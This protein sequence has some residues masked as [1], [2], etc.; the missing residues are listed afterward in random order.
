VECE[1]CKEIK[2]TKKELGAD[3]KKIRRKKHWQR[4]T[5]VAKHTNIK[6]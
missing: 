2:K 4:K 1:S 3:V 6:E 5:I